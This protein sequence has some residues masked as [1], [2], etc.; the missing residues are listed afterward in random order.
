MSPRPAASGLL[1]MRACHCVDRKNSAI[2]LNVEG[3][4]GRNGCSNGGLDAKVVIEGPVPLMQLK[5][6]KVHL[7]KMP[8]GSTPASHNICR[9]VDAVVT[10]LY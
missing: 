9:F 5:E 8:S 10:R 1:R 3:G 4:G 2:D 7:G 6:A